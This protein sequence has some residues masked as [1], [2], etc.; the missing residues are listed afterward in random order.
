L[1]NGHALASLS[2][3]VPLLDSSAA[4]FHYGDIE[5]AVFNSPSWQVAFPGANT[6]NGGVTANEV[7]YAFQVTDNGG[8]MNGIT[9][10][11][12]GIADLGPPLN[13]LHHGDGL[14]DDELVTTGDSSYVVGTGAAPSAVSAI[15]SSV[16]WR[17]LGASAIK[18]TTSAVLFYT[19]PYGPTW[20]NGSTTTGAGQSRIPAPE[21]GVPIPEGG[22]PEPSTI[23]LAF[24]A[25][26][27]AMG[28]RR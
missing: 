12:A 25:V 24:L 5:Y 26:L 6:P 3:I 20:D 9:Q 13:P 15:G 28:R 21:V 23:T 16:P 8:R 22:I 14:N 27:G 1:L 19:S 17:F 18:S 7:V 11:T 2:G 4:N 10:F